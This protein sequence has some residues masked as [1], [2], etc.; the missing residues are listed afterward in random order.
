VAVDGELLWAQ[1]PLRF[2][3]ASQP[4]MLLV[5]AEPSQDA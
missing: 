2:T 5:P 3:V 1:P 4:L